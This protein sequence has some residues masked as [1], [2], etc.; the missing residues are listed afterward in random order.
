MLYLRILIIDVVD[1]NILLKKWV[2]QY[3]QHDYLEEE[4]GAAVASIHFELLLLAAGSED[5]LGVVL[6]D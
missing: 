3:Q 4:P 6:V 5:F 2:R 1:V